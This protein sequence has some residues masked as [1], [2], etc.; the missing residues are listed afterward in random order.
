[1]PQIQ[2]IKPNYDHSYL[3]N[4]P[5]FIT[6]YPLIEPKEEIKREFLA[7]EKEGFHKELSKQKATNAFIWSWLLASFA[8][9]IVAIRYAYKKIKA[10][11]F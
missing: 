1:M 4:S 7:I 9:M 8:G 3:V 2:P 11:L 10:A 6:N 5:P